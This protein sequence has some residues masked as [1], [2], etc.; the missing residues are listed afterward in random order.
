VPL[1]KAVS[2]GDKDFD[3]LH[4]DIQM[5]ATATIVNHTLTFIIILPLEFMITEPIIPS[6][7]P[8]FLARHELIVNGKRFEE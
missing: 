2:S 8:Y 1:I 3:L 5:P 6:V 4:P 7:H